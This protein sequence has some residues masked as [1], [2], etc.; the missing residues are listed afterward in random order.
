AIENE[1]SQVRFERLTQ[2]FLVEQYLL[3]PVLATERGV[4]GYEDRLDDLQRF[5]LREDRDRVRAYLHAIDKLSL[6]ELSQES[7]IDYR[8][9]RSSAQRT[10]FALEQ[11]RWPERRPDRYLHLLFTGLH[12]LLIRPFSGTERR[13][14][15]LLGR[16][17]AV[18]DA[19]REAQHNLKH[20]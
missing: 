9:A 17:Q 8:L 5:A 18:P 1:S 19:L 2:E 13:A 10:L 11:Q 14:L 6:A 3:H 4:Y 12:L 20:P 16:L 15:N 7:R